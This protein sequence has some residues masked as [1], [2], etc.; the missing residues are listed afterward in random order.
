MLR[1]C[2]GSVGVISLFGFVVGSGGSFVLLPWRGGRAGSFI[3]GGLFFV[4]GKCRRLSRQ[5]RAVGFCLG[6]D[7]CFSCG[8]WGGC[9]LSRVSLGVSWCQSP[10]SVL[11]YRAEM[12]LRLAVVFA[13]Q[14]SQLVELRVGLSDARHRPMLALI[15]VALAFALAELAQSSQPSGC[16]G[17]CALRLA[18]QACSILA[19]RFCSLLFFW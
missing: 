17:L 10:P 16:C 8:I 15:I 14:G 6:R 7:S 9:L 4:V 19:R 18:R 3:G 13:C 12:C 2:R 11:F 1:I 5:S